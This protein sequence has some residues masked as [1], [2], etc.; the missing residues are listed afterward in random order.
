LL[1]HRELKLLSDESR[2]VLHH[3][4]TRPLAT[5]LDFTIVRTPNKAVSPALQ[6]PV[7]FVGHEI[8]YQVRKWTSLGSFL[9][10]R[11]LTNPFSISHAFKN[12]RLSVNRR[13]SPT[14]LAICPSVIVVDFKGP[15]NDPS[16]Q[17]ALATS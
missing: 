8:A 11:G 1:I 16:P 12:A 2:N 9:Y 7:E 10:A 14:G 4:L 5:N 15:F 17:K 6:L 13:L 3:P